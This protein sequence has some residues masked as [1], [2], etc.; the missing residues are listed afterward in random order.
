MKKYAD[1]ENSINKFTSLDLSGIDEYY[2]IGE[3]IRK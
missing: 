3:Q 1:I 2:M